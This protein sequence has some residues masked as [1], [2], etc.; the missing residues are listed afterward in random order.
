MNLLSVLKKLNDIFPELPP[1]ERRVAEYIINNSSL[2]PQMVIR[3]IAD[4]VNVSQPTV[5]H[6][7]RR[8]GYDGYMAFKLALAV[9]TVGSYDVNASGD[10]EKHQDIITEC[11]AEL[12]YAIAETSKSIEHIKLED[13]AIRICRAN[14]VLVIAEGASVKLAE[15]F[16]LRLSFLEINAI[17]TNDYY[18]TANYADWLRSGD[19]IIYMGSRTTNKNFFDTI[20]SAKRNGISS[21][22]ITNVENPLLTKN[23]DYSFVCHGVSNKVDVITRYG[24]NSVINA[25]LCTLF[26]V[27]TYQKMKL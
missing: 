20:S 7:T 13:L 17:A 3:E 4:A 16:A 27:I 6:L 22:V 26:L 5:T 9:D 14:K 2:A 18:L 15:Y 1:A 10:D 24:N 19:V 25:F 8:L 11:F 12:A 23:C 21:A